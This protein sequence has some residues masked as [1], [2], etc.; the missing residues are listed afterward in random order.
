MVL[1]GL[2][3]A[4]APFEPAASPAPSRDGRAE[5]DGRAVAGSVTGARAVVNAFRA[6][7]GVPV[8]RQSAV[9]SRV[10]AGHAADLV[11]TGRFSHR[12]RDGSNVGDRA[13]RAGYR[14]VSLPRTSPVGRA[15]WRR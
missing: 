5:Q 10:A 12:G 11:A 9:L 14:F 1:S 7:A 13:H 8:L 3:A 4:C 2:L 15:A 6:R